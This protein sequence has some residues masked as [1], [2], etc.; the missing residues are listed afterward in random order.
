MQPRLNMAWIIMMA[1]AGIFALLYIWFTL[2]PGKLSPES[3][4]Y[5]SIDQANRGREYSQAPRLLFIAAFMS[6]SAFLI[7]IF[8]R[9]H[10]ASLSRWAQSLTGS[11][12]GGLLAL[13]LT[14]WIFLQLINLPFSLFGSY[15]WQHRWGF[16]TQSLGSWW[17][18]YLK[19]AGLELALSSAGAILLFWIMGRW[20]K[21]WWLLGAALFSL[22]LI[23][24]SFL[25]PVVVSPLF[26]R[27]EP[28]KSPSV[29][30]MVKELSRKAGLPVDQVLVMDAS[31][32][33]TKANA[34]FTGLGKTKRIV[35]YDTLLA[36]YPPDQV[37]AVVA[38]EMAHWSRGHIM[39]GLTMGVLGNFIAWGLLFLILGSTLQAPGRYPPQTWAA[40]LLFFLLFS[41]LASPVQNYISR[42]MEVEA[43]R[44]SVELTGDPQAATRLQLN[45]AAKNLSDVSPHPFIRWFSYSHP[46][47]PERIKNIRVSGGA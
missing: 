47:A 37:K 7:W 23:V 42:K 5:F 26:N 3:L 2:F 27:F 29:V 46:P 43:D 30:S 25:W 14:L 34:Y 24:Q 17:A 19:W 12:W 28:A 21:S 13:F 16:S 8:F 20:P 10:A 4:Q 39:K 38:H 40:V 36:N 35:L 44:V 6:Q 31:Q 45:L 11:Y 9:G 33:T 22:W 41:F 1:T 18:D 32:R 15:Y